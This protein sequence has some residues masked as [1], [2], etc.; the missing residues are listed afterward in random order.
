MKT[1]WSYQATLFVGLI[2]LVLVG[3]G[4]WLAMLSNP[5][6]FSNNVQN[7]R[8]IDA[9]AGGG[10]LCAVVG[11]GV[12]LLAV[13]RMTTS[14]SPEKRRQTNAAIGMGLVFQLTGI[15]MIQMGLGQSGSGWALLLASF[16]LFALGA[17]YY[18]QAKGYSRQLGALG[19]LGI[20]GLI[21]LILLPGRELAE[22]A[23]DES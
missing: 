3:T 1:V 10:F 9:Y 5:A 6:R 2:G 21:V 13:S 16:P 20:V 7:D 11:V 4:L 19:I 14:L 23:E 15:V 18:A 8:I 12:F 22:R 17:M